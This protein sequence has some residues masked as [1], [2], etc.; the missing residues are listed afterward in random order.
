MAEKK[1]GAICFKLH[2]SGTER[3]LAI[4]DSE[5][6]GQ[7]FIVEKTGAKI[8]ISAEF[9]GNEEGS[10][11][12][13]EAALR[14]ATSVNLIGSKALKAAGFPEKSA[15]ILACP[16]KNIPHIQAVFVSLAED[17]EGP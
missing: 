9:Y 8:G 17:R 5:L 2:C 13:L 16:G 4:S 1:D 12:E 6:V 15:T 7:T 11:G 10:P 3:I 14:A